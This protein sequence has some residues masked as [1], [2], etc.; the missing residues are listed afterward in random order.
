MFFILNVSLLNAQKIKVD[1]TTAKMSQG[2]K[3]GLRVVIPGANAKDVEKAWKKLLKDFGGKVSSSKGEIFSDNST[4]KSFGSNSVDIYAIVEG[5]DDESE[6]TVFFDLGGAYVNAAQHGGKYA[7]VEQ[8][9]R[10]FAV[11]AAK[12]AVSAELEMAE[13]ALKT[14]EGDQK[15]LEKENG[16]LKESIEKY[17]EAIAKAEEDIIQNEKDQEAKKLAIAEQKKAVDAVSKKLSTIQ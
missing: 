1:E 3:K 5:N 16:Q 12:E 4:I 10:S 8:I 7:T 15:K 17:K 14:Y 6:L 11:D 13:K 2:F 9:V